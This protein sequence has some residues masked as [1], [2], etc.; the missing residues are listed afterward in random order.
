[1]GGSRHTNVDEVVA[2]ARKLAVPLSLHGEIDNTSLLG[3]YEQCDIFLALSEHEGFG[4]P[5]FEAMRL[6][7]PVVTL[8]STAIKDL[9]CRHPLGTDVLDYREIALRVVAALDPR[10]REL[11]VAWQRDQILGK[12][13]TQIVTRQLRDGIAGQSRWPTGGRCAPCPSVEDSVEALRAALWT[14][15]DQASSALNALQEL[16]KDTPERFVTRYDIAAY[17]ALLGRHGAATNLHD[18]ALAQSFISSRPFLGPPLR[19]ARRVALSVQ[20]GLVS[21]MGMLDANVSARFE[22]MERLLS[23][24]QGSLDA[25]R[26]PCACRTVERPA[27]LP[28]DRDARE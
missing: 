3:L 8:R 5:L 24:L 6:A 19:F 26:E 25:M 12:Y 9:L 18:A 16:P 14:R 7:I 13:D 22:R 10:N 2:L 1:L 11:V 17:S 23:G 28:A 27:M 4:L 20:S 15:L 21:A